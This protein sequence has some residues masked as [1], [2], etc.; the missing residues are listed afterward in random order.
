[1]VKDAGR[2]AAAGARRR[3]KSVRV[4]DLR[5]GPGGEIIMDFVAETTDLGAPE[6]A[7]TGIASIERISVGQ[8]RIAKYSRRK[9]GNFILFYEVWD[10]QIWKRHFGPYEA[11]MDVIDRTLPPNGPEHRMGKH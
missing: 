4:G 2:K 11:A 3:R 8:V 9:D 1:M 5:R 6:Y 10:Y 7:V